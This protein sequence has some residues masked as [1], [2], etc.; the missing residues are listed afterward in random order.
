MKNRFDQTLNLL[1][2]FSE[3]VSS[4]ADLNKEKHK[5]THLVQMAN[6]RVQEANFLLGANDKVYER[7]MEVLSEMG[8]FNFGLRLPEVTTDDENAAMVTVGLNMLNDEYQKWAMHKRLVS[9][10]FDALELPDKMAI[11]TDV[12]GSITFIHPGKTNQFE[13]SSEKLVGLYINSIFEDFTAID[14]LIKTEGTLRGIQTNLLWCGQNIPVSLNISFSI[15]AGRIDGLVYAFTFL[16][17]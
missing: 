14:E 8:I 16:K 1:A 17:H 15:F 12:E 9:T 7:M 5:L 10:I 3:I 6:L 11:V 2:D 13:F 4:D